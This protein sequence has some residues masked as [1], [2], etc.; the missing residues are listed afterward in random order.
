M[1]LLD[2]Q[3]IS[4]IEK[5]KQRDHQ[6]FRWLV[7]S[8]QTRV[9]N[10]ANAYLHSLQE[11]EDIAQDVFIEVFNSIHKFRG[12]ST[13][14]TWIYRI[15]VNKSLNRRK[16]LIRMSFFGTGILSADNNE[17]QIAPV[18]PDTASPDHGIRNEEDKKALHK[19]IDK[20][21]AQ[22]KTAFIL[23]KYEL[24]SYKEIAEVMNVSMSA[25]E[26][27]LFRAKS[28]LRKHL[29]SYINQK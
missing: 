18:A 24:L 10:L 3:E 9:I 29:S 26:S 13:I 25:V 7:D 6:A 27:L 22:Q 4:L 14:S 20:L 16:K 19:A 2:M 21:P 23:N 12:S 5:L 15:T 28:N 8:Y 1:H 17:S 11:A